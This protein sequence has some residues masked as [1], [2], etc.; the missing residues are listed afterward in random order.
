MT[1]TI[2][3]LNEPYPFKLPSSEGA[4]SD[5]LRQGSNRLLITMFDISKEEEKILRKG[6]MRCGFLKKGGAILFLWQFKDKKGKPF[7]TLDSPF[8]ARLINDIEL[9]DIDNKEVRVSVDV[10]IVDISTNLV[11]GLRSITM[12]PGL[13]LEFLSAVQDQIVCLNNG[14]DQI[15]K[16]MS[17]EPHVLCK[18]TTMWL[19]GK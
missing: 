11:R 8:D 2:L 18:Q 13:T 3:S 14:D 16:W 6:E 19:M 1:H 7:L 9:Y 5:F 17:V 12:P 10:H 4:I 15:Q